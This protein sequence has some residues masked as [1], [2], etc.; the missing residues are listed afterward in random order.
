MAETKDNKN[1]E[2]KVKVTIETDGEIEVG[3]AEQKQEEA[4]VEAPAKEEAPVEAPKV[5]ESDK[6]AERIE[7]SNEK[8]LKAVIETVQ[9][10]WQPKSEVAESKE[11]GFV[12]E[13]FTDEEA[14][15]FMDKLFES[16]INSLNL[17]MVNLPLIKTDGLLHT[18]L[19][20]NTMELSKRQFQLLE[21][22]Q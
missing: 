6:V 18:Q 11:K 22:F 14:T 12:E 7:A 2:E 20:K 1:V 13:A 10:A 3:K 4:P 8:T 5:S 15:Q 17:D 16:G 19:P 9:S 21:L